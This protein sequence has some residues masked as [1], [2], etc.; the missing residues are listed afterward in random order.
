[1]TMSRT[2][3]RRE[4]GAMSRPPLV[5]GALSVGGDGGSS[6]PSF[7]PTEKRRVWVWREA[8]AFVAAP[9]ALGLGHT[10]RLLQPPV[11]NSNEREF[12]WCLP[13]SE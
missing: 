13:K 1:V 9:A 11:V 6:L 3:G 8:A 4:E 10:G 12:S 2:E 5:V 7:L